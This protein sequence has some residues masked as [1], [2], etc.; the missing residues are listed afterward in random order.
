M[1]PHG[2]QKR[3]AAV[4]LLAATFAAA[5]CGGGGQEVSDEEAVERTV[6]AAMAR[7]ADP[8]SCLLF[9]TR[10]FLELMTQREGEAAVEA[11][12]ENA[13]DPVVEQ[14]ERV[15]VSRVKVEDDSATALVAFEGSSLDGQT[16]EYA[17]VSRDERWKFDDMLA[18]VDFD[19]D[20][21]IMALGREFMLR[22]ESAQEA[23]YV[24]CL[25]DRMEEMS[26]EV[27]EEIM[28]GGS[29]E[30][31]LELADGCFAGSSAI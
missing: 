11:C 4:A 3:L 29:Q 27:L 25:I 9:S 22:A 2:L 31:L 15:E 26:A 13:L 7:G 16:V 20:K 23:G 6:I 1:R 30:P 19:D 28:L 21:M 5:S 17:F 14:P 18:Y 8:E 12:E 24:A 10:H